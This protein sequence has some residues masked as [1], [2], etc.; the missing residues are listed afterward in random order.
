[1][2]MDLFCIAVMTFSIVSTAF[3]WI[4]WKIYGKDNVIK[5]TIEVYPPE[6]CNSLEVGWL[7]KGEVNNESI[8]SLLIYL[9]DKGYL[10]IEDNGRIDTKFIKLKDYDGENEIEEKFLGEIFKNGSE[11]KVS[12][13]SGN[14]V[15]VFNDIKEKYFMKNEEIY[16]NSANEKSYWVKILMVFIFVFSIS[17]FVLAKLNIIDDAAIGEYLLTFIVGLICIV[18]LILFIKIMPK[19]TAYGTEMLE[20]ITGFK[21]FIYNSDRNKLKEIVNNNPKYFSNTLAYSYT[22]GE[23]SRWIKK[24]ETI[25]NEVPDWYESNNRS[26]NNF[27]SF[28]IYTMTLIIINMTSTTSKIEV[29]KKY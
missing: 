29:E 20:K 11:V 8:V 15:E 25:I 28:M 21:N 26:F 12:E 24:F 2:Q 14:F 10:K 18:F 4:L 19:R 16:E 6:N 9:A 23:A 13:L 7:Y 17:K 5:E 27:N 22:L 1:M 3:A